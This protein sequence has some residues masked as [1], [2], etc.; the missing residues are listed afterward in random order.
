MIRLKWKPGP[1]ANLQ[2]TV[3][4]SATR[5]TYRHSWHVPLVFWHGLKLRSAWGDIQGAVGVSISSDLLKRTT[6]TVS[7]WKSEQAL[8]EWLRSP[9]HAALMRDYRARLSSSDAASW[10]TDHFLLGDAWREAMRRLS[11]PR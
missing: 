7:V 1:S 5:F 8:T 4:V 11:P 3:F 10:Q 9:Y 6:Y 2:G